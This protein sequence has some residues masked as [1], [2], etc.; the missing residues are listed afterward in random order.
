MITILTFVCK[1]LFRHLLVGKCDL[2]LDRFYCFC[3]Y[4]CSLKQIELNHNIIS[5]LRAII[6]YVITLFKNK[7]FIQICILVVKLHNISGPITK[8]NPFYCQLHSLYM[9]YSYVWD[10]LWFQYANKYVNPIIN[11]SKLKTKKIGKIIGQ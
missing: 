4:R 8:P 6:V 5:V 11:F 1:H 10:M 7:S 2:F 3:S 9:D